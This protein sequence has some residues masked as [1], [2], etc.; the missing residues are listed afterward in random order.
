[1]DYHQKL[2][3]KNG[4]STM[5]LAK[6]FMGC[7][8]GSKVPTVSEFN[9][10]IGLAR[11]T[12]QNSIKLLQENE[13]IKLESKGHL[14]TYLVSKNTRILLAF[15]GITSIVG[16]M[17]L[18]YSKKYE[19]LATGLIVAMENQYNIPASMAYMR[20]AENRIAMLLA[21]RYDFAV[22]SKY[23]AIDLNKRNDSIVIVKAFGPHSYLSNH[24]I[25]FHD[26]QAKEIVDGM[27]VGIDV[28]SID[29]K[30]MTKKACENKQVEL[31]R[32]DYN[33]ILEK[34]I[35][36]S[37]DAAVWNEDIITDKTLPINYTRIELDDNDD[38]EAVIVVNKKR[39]ELQNVID[40]IINVD[41]VLDIQKLVVESKI[42]PS[43]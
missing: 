20:G 18:P 6:E 25:L 4:L 43:Y 16:V 28:E 12:I 3:S 21:E 30:V 27:K 9:E 29:Q 40:D 24:V 31:V 36:G 10:R 35:Q 1:M 15:A 41:T 17:P 13:A 34:I 38:T 8:I 22:V 14:G 33:Q 5:A 26:K 19:G 23:A 42:T 11:G 37:I 39:P 2:L 7:K 32:V